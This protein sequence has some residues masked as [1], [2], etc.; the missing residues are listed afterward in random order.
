MLY[1]FIKSLYI[2]ILTDIF[3]QITLSAA[4]FSACGSFLRD[5][6]RT[7]IP[8]TRNTRRGYPAVHK[9]PLT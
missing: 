1:Q 2:Y 6:K 5:K 8:S 7:L 4:F 9:T 3:K